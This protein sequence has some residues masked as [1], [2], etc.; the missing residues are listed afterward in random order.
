MRFWKP[1]AKR[2][3]ALVCALAMTASLLPTAVFADTGETVS[4]ASSS[5]TEEEKTEEGQNTPSVPGEQ[6]KEQPSPE[7]S[8]SPAPSAEPTPSASPEVTP[9]PSE[10]PEPVETPATTP[11]ASPEG[12]PEPTESPEPA[13]NEVQTFAAGAPVAR[14]PEA[15]GT[16]VQSKDQIFT[17]DYHAGPGNKTNLTVI[18]QDEAGN[19]IDRTNV[20]ENA[21]RDTS[22]MSIT[23]NEAYLASFEL[24]NVTGSD[25]VTIY[26]WS[27]DFNDAGEKTFTWRA[28]GQETAT[29]YVT[30]GEQSHRFELS[31]GSVNLGSILWKEGGDQLTNVEAYLNYEL[32]Y[33]S[34]YVH[35]SNS[36]NNFDLTVN[37]GYYF[38]TEK[39]QNIKWDSEVDGQ[40]FTLTPVGDYNKL[41]FGVIPSLPH[42]KGQKNTIKLYFFT[43][44]NPDGL[45]VDF[46]RYI[47]ENAAPI[48]PENACD[49]LKISFDYKGKD[50]SFDYT[51]FSQTGAVFLPKDV[52]ITVE[53]VIKDGYHFE[54]WHTGDAWTAGNDLYTI[55]SDGTWRKEITGTAGLQEGRIAFSQTMGMK[56]SKDASFDRA[57]I[58]LHLTDGGLL[59]D[60]NTNPNKTITYDPNYEGG[61]DAYVQ[62]YYYTTGA[63]ILDNMFTR[64]GYTFKGW[65]TASDGSGTTYA[66]DSLYGGTDNFTLYAQWEESKPEEPQKPDDDTVIELLKS[67]VTTICTNEDA[68][69][70]DLPSD[71]IAGSFTVRDVRGDATSG[72]TIEVYINNPAAYA[73]Q[74]S[75]AR[76]SNHT[77]DDTAPSDLLL[78]LVYNAADNAWE[79][80]QDNGTATIYVVCDGSTEPEVP[81]MPTDEQIKAALQGMVAVDCIND[82]AEPAHETKYYGLEGKRDKDYTVSDVAGDPEKGYSVTVTLKGSSVNEL[83]VKQ[84]NGDVPSESGHAL[85]LN[86]A[87]DEDVTLFYDAEKEVWY[88]NGAP[89]TYEVVCED[90]TPAVL[91]EGP[92]PED[93]IDLL[94]DVTV[95]CD[96]H[97]DKAF[98]VE[99][100]SLTYGL[101]HMDKNGL[102]VLDIT[103]R[104]DDYVAQYCDNFGEHELADDEVKTVTL[105]YAGSGWT[106]ANKDFAGVTFNVKCVAP[107]APGFDT[108]KGLLG[109]VKLVCGV[110]GETKYALIENAVKIDGVV[111]GGY[112]ATVKVTVLGNG[113]LSDYNAQNAA[114]IGE[115]AFAGS[116]TLTVELVYGQNGWSVAAND[117]DT[118]AN[119]TFNIKC[120]A[121]DAPGEEN[122]PSGDD[123]NNNNNNNNNNNTNNNQNKSTASASASASAAVTAPAAAAV[124][125]QTGDEM[126]VGLLAG[127]AVVAAGGLAALLVLR[128]RRS[129]R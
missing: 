67:S 119:L 51:D 79:V 16:V 43:Y 9:E 24:K 115:H 39:M 53:P 62:Y 122:K 17:V 21:Y 31:N 82:K 99:E 93:V 52:N 118:A 56:Y 45:N 129:D 25:G 95:T 5:V 36:L 64:E 75:V 127:L 84:Y 113:Y 20:I 8:E 110:H 77:Y 12:T 61:P 91:P 107:E 109:D 54:Y 60:P 70:E 15:R 85:I 1:R 26:G 30:V 106:F 100:D 71:L 108:V 66:V 7:P 19:E 114:T 42:T 6:P 3:A 87:S 81:D 65:N 86:K 124:I 112:G 57:Q 104:A 22:T 69:H 28:T 74:Y 78:K 29:I 98:P 47:N 111:G 32:I 2:L 59:E 102:V 120:V 73:D 96:E 117:R 105:Q 83:Y 38:D 37:E 41:T 123:D 116:K 33:T 94:G 128:K 18:M 80:S 101:V 34:D 14:A 90:G 89:V 48:H 55:K 97:G 76:N 72:Y 121:P 50:Y 10:S 4:V 103:V 13:P 27:G 46:T 40:S 125:P 35:I 68:G 88:Y 126:P 23:L 63:M 58:I 92:E 11:S 44:D 49:T